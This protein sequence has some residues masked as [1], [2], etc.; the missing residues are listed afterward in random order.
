MKYILLLCFIL[1]NGLLVAQ[2][3]ISGKILDKKTKQPVEGVSVFL[4][5]TT[6]GTVTNNK[7]EFQLE[8]I[9]P[10]KYELIAKS[11]NYE[12]FVQFIQTAEENQLL[13]ITLN[14]T[15]NMLKDVIVQQYDE[16]GWEKWGAIFTSYFIGSP[17]LSKKCI[18]KNPEAVKF[19]YNSKTNKLIAFSNENLI[20]NNLTLGYKITYILEKFEIDFTENTFSFNGYPLF[21]ELKPKNEK[22]ASQWYLMRSNTYKGS[23]HHFINSLYK[24]NLVRDSFEIRAIQIIDDE[25]KT[26]VKKILKNLHG[27]VITTD[28]NNYYQKVRGLGP[29]EY[30][31]VLDKLIPCNSIVQFSL[32]DSNSKT[33]YFT[34]YLEI[35]FLKKRIPKEYAKIL[36]VY[37]SNEFIKNEIS[38]RS[39]TPIKLYPNSN[40]YDGYNLLIEGFWAW[41][42]KLATMLPS[43]YNL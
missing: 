15:T 20:F 13:V 34:N 7:G 40:Y 16:N 29:N 27:E 30:K 4:S 5:K 6:I 28:S 39:N 31:V 35:T 21:Q 10:G 17:D 23:L 38:L 43:N 3:K 32:N 8:G 2:Y 25:E 42:E 1:I 26:R 22:Q 33:L 11:L 18:F 24:D 12:E 19:R 9:K 36:P 41:S 37:R 14:P